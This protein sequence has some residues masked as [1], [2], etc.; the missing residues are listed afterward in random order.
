[1]SLQYLWLHGNKQTIIGFVATIAYAGPITENAAEDQLAQDTQ[2]DRVKRSFFHKPEGI[3]KKKLVWKDEWVKIWR[4]EKKQEWKQDWKKI[5]VPAWKIIDVPVWKEIKIPEWKVNKVPAWIE[6]DVPIWK[7]E[8]VP[9]WKKVSKPVWKEIQ[10]PSWKE[11]Q[12]PDWKQIWV[13][14]WVKV[15]QQ[16]SL[17]YRLSLNYKFCLSRLE[18]PERSS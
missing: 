16:H 1:M 5:T 15:C 2:I 8:K 7:E 18:F 3:W 12:V 10:V 17:I 4:I 14:E 11:I 13:P 9:D 6:I